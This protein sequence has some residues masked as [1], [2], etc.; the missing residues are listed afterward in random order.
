MSPAEKN[1]PQVTMVVITGH[2]GAGK[3]EAIAAF[4]DGGYFCV[5]TDSTEERLVFNRTATL[6]ES[7]G[8]TSV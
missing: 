1:E 3:S 8:K 7:W 5:D 4:E 6:K 2:S